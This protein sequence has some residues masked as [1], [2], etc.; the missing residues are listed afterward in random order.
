MLFSFSD[1]CSG[2]TEWHRSSRVVTSLTWKTQYVQ[3]TFLIKGKHQ[4]WGNLTPFIF[5]PLPP[6]PL[7]H[8]AWCH[9]CT[10]GKNGRDSSALH[11][12]GALWGEHQYVTNTMLNWAIKWHLVCLAL[13]SS[14]E[15]PFPVAFVSSNDENGER[16]L[17]CAPAGPLSRA[18]S[19]P[20]KQGTTHL[21]LHTTTSAAV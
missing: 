1:Q 13:N 19:L 8:T 10:R 11:I 20:R 5:W 16:T 3:M 2:I 4:P 15:F 18:P 17:H 21:V 6:D 12:R 14:S 7:S 9:Q